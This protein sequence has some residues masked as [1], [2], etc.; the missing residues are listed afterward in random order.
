VLGLTACGGSQPAPAA[1]DAT[2]HDLN[3]DSV[4]PLDAPSPDGSESDSGS[5]NDATHSAQP[6]PD[7]GQV[8]NDKF[9]LQNSDGPKGAF[10][11]AAYKIKQTRTEA[12]M[13]FIVVDKDKGPIEGVV[14]ALTAPGGEKYHTGE[15]DKSGYAEVLVPVGQEYGIVY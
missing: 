15:T 12:A 13:K 3:S 5:I 7:N 10:G 11:A 4:A 9:V 6:T 8:D 14:I 1:A 2:Q